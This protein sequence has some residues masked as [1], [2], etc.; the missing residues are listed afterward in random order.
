M[1]AGRLRHRIIIQEPV[2]ARNGYNETITTWARVAEV[3]ASVEPLSGREFFDAEHQQSDITHRVVLRFRGGITAE[4]R[5][6]HHGRDLRVQSVI[7][8]K[9]R[10]REL[11]L[12]CRETRP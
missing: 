5:V 11:Q 7:N 6:L 3:W 2:T 9:E 4:M 1:Q 12:M 10:G 8:A